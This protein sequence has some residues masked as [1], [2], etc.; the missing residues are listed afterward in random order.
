KREGFYWL[1]VL[2]TFAL[3]TAAGDLIAERL[4]VGYA[5]SVVLFAGAIAVVT[6]LHYRLNLNAVIPFSA[7][8][9][10]TRPPGAPVGD[11]LSQTRSS[12]GLGLGTTVPTLVFLSANLVVVSSLSVTKRDVSAAGPADRPDPSAGVLVVAHRMTAATPALL[13]A[14]RARAAGG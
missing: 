1:A 8:Y 12:G 14:I 7:A 4:N 9:I 6:A 13:E 5:W 10:L 3:G 2:F 11:L